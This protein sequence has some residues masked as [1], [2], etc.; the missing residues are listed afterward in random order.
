MSS[1]RNAAFRSADLHPHALLY[2]RP[3]ALLLPHALPLPHPAPARLSCTRTCTQK[4][5][6]RAATGSFLYR[7]TRLQPIRTVAE[8]EVTFAVFT[9][10]PFEWQRIAGEAHR[11]RRLG[12]TFRAIGAALGVDEKQVRKALRG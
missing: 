3:H 7:W 6:R 9:H 10:E 2:P 5:T 8:V 1:E 12:M 11:L 4:K